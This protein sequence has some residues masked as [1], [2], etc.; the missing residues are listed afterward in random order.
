MPSILGTCNH[1]IAIIIVPI[2]IC[3]NSFKT[4]PFPIRFAGWVTV[5]ILFNLSKKESNKFIVN[6]AVRLSLTVKPVLNQFD[7]CKILCHQFFKQFFI[8]C[9]IDVYRTIFAY[10]NIDVTDNWFI[11][12]NRV[13]LLILRIKLH[14]SLSINWH[15]IAV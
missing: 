9:I 4:F 13:F 14:M 1:V 2:C 12:I 8:S 15:R 10:R 6:S 5:S 7:H 3:T 11:D